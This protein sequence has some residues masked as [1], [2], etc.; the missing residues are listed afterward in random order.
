M[1][2]PVTIASEP[3]SSVRERVERLW[4]QSGSAG[5]TDRPELEAELESL[6]GLYRSNRNEFTADLV[7]ML[8]SIAAGLDAISA[9]GDSRARAQTNVRIR[10][11]SARA[12]RHREERA[13]RSRL[14]RHH[15][16][17]RREVAHV[18]TS[19]AAP[20]RA[21]ARRV[22]AHRAHERPGGR[23]RRAR[24]ARHVPEFEP[25]ARRTARARRAAA[26]R[27][28][29]A[30]LRRTRGARGVGG[31]AARRARSEAHRR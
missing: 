7:T 5:P 30:A 29:R 16:D 3:A 2:F 28:V 14:H 9:S 27:R 12:A 1:R 23:A 25:I 17:R 22:A 6:R 15:A 19:G 31:A 13:R 18:S 8:R 10:T 11:F 20:R 26:I 21:H 4:Q 24:P